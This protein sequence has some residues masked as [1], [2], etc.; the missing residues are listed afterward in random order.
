MIKLSTTRA[1]PNFITWFSQN[2]MDNYIKR[3][4]RNSKISN[5]WTLDSNPNYLDWRLVG[6]AF[7]LTFQ[8]TLL[9]GIIEPMQSNIESTVKT[10]RLI[11][12]L[13]LIP[14]LTV[15]GL[16]IHSI[17]KRKNRLFYIGMTITI[18]PL[19]TIGTLGLVQDSEMPY[20]NIIMTIIMVPLTSWTNKRGLLGIFGVKQM[21][22]KKE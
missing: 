16:I 5:S 21:E 7:R 8:M 20:K 1:K 3:N 2:V 4:D 18:I 13:I 9:R 17:R 19:L 10:R 15:F 14:V 11:S 22:L 6:L 12:T